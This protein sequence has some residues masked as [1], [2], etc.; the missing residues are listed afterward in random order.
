MQKV[1]WSAVFWET[2]R[3]ESGGNGSF[4]ANRFCPPAE[5]SALAAA[6]ALAGALAEALADALAG[7]MNVPYT[8]KQLLSWV[9][10]HLKV[11]CEKTAHVFPFQL[12]RSGGELAALQR[13]YYTSLLHASYK[14]RKHLFASEHLHLPLPTVA[15]VTACSPTNAWRPQPSLR[16]NRPL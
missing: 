7:A 16:T 6:L 13:N 11:I 4:G 9:S 8:V 10:H 15:E 1:S 12:A 3:S 2:R 14:A 5:A